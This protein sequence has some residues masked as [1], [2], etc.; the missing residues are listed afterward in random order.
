MWGWAHCERGGATEVAGV[1]SARARPRARLRLQPHTP[2]TCHHG[3]R[4]DTRQLQ[5]SCRACQILI[6]FIFISINE[7][8]CNHGGCLPVLTRLHHSTNIYLSAS[9]II[10]WP[11]KVARFSIHV[12]LQAFC[13]RLLGNVRE[14]LCKINVRESKKGSIYNLRI[15]NTGAFSAWLCM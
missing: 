15:F 2:A 1:R 14:S 8:A 10:L 6:K 12:D 7:Y 3:L 9:Q 13:L 4:P 11:L 5:S